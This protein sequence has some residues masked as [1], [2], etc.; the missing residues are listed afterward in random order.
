M[1]TKTYCRY[2]MDTTEHVCKRCGTKSA[3]KSSLVRHLHSK[4]ICPASVSDIDRDDFLKELTTR[5]YK[6]TTTTCEFC[7]K[8]VSKPA[9]ARHLKTCKANKE[10]MP[11]EN[12]VVV[13]NDN[14]LQLLLELKEQVDRLTQQLAS[15]NCQDAQPL[16]ADGIVN[17]TTYIINLNTYGQ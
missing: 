5:D 8:T 16:K 7:N 13:T 1:N 14:S 4:S 9:Y 3:T 17:N 6:T 10:P 12:E 2:T 11:T 15:Q